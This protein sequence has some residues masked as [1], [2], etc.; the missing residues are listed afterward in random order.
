MAAV[1]HKEP[2]APVPQ[3]NAQLTPQTTT[4]D[5]RPAP[6]THSQVSAL[7]GGRLIVVA[8]RLP[9]VRYS[10]RVPFGDP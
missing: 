8:N 5:T 6:R 3:K 2:A 1:R 7:E 4:H 9:V 10:T